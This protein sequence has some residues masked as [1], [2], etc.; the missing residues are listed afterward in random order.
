MEYGIGE[1]FM[2]ILVMFYGVFSEDYDEEFVHDI[3]LAQQ[4]L[5]K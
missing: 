4:Q 2:G 5:Q 3:L 1:W